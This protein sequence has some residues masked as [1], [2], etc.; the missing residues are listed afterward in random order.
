[1]ELLFSFF[2]G[3]QAKREEDADGDRHLPA[4]ASACRVSARS[5]FCRFPSGIFFLP[6][7]CKSAWEY[8]SVLYLKK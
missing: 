5:T 2:L 3:L 8:R 4:H 7:D 1:M 6:L